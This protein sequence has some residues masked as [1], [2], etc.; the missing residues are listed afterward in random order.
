MF[1]LSLSTEWQGLASPHPPSRPSGGQL[2]S[3]LP[4]KLR[5]TPGPLTPGKCPRHPPRR[6]ELCTQLLTTERPRGSNEN[7]GE[8]LVSGERRNS[9]VRT[10]ERPDWPNAGGEGRQAEGSAGAARRLQI[11]LA[12]GG[13]GTRGGTAGGREHVRQPAPPA[14]HAL[15]APCFRGVHW[16]SRTPCRGRR[17]V[18]VMDL[19]NQ[20]PNKPACR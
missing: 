17:G 14:C 2:L 6:R 13:L 11:A 19:N 1:T 15:Y 8:H 7:E 16:L 3:S 4:G 12:Q 20:D 18:Q 9:R 10:A 5:C